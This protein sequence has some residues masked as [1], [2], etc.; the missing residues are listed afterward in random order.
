MPGTEVVEVA[1]EGRLNRGTQFMD[2][3]AKIWLWLGERFGARPVTIIGVTVG[4]IIFA[5]A[6][7]YLLVQ[8]NS[9][10]QEVRRVTSAFCNGS[11]KFRENTANQ[12][13]C[14][15][16]LRTLIKNPDEDNARQL[17][18]IVSESK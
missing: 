12:D 8:Q 9:T 13:R 6:L 1:D 16:L 5:S 2:F 3:C 14:N 4:A 17:R 7:T 10:S 15:D 11:D 18:K